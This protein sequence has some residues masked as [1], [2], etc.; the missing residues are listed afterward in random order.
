MNPQ[1]YGGLEETCVCDETVSKTLRRTMQLKWLSNSTSLTVGNLTAR[2]VSELGHFLVLSLRGVCGLSKE[3]PEFIADGPVR[4]T[5][6]RFS[7]GC[8]KKHDRWHEQRNRGECNLWVR[9]ASD[10]ENASR[11]N[12]EKIAELRKS[13]PPFEERD[14]HSLALCPPSEHK[15]CR[16]G[17]ENGVENGQY[18]LSDRAL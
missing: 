15:L 10:G 16:L 6:R 9:D 17:L 13:C 7:F 18:T 12:S 8:S 5:L 3:A 4:I 11:G 2:I 14:D 1:S